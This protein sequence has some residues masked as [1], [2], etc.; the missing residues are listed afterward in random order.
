MEGAKKQLSQHGQES[1]VRLNIDT[2]NPMFDGVRN[3]DIDQNDLKLENYQPSPE[4]HR[5]KFPLET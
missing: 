4:T 3:I 1:K 5:I 2:E